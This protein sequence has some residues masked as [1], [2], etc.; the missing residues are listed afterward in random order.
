MLGHRRDELRVD[1]REAQWDLLLKDVTTQQGFAARAMYRTEGV[2]GVGIIRKSRGWMVL[3]G[4]AVGGLLCWWCWEIGGA[5]AAV[6]GTALF[7]FDPNF[8]GHSPLVKND[9]AMTLVMLGMMFALWR[10]GRR[11]TIW[12]LAAVCA[13]LA[14]GLG[15]KFSGVLLVPML[16]LILAIRVML[17]DEWRVLRWNVATRRGRLLVGASV[18]AAAMLLSWVLVWGIYSFR[19][20]PAARGGGQ[21][22]FAAMIQRIKRDSYILEHEANAPADVSALKAPVLA[23]VVVWAWE[24][25]VLPESW[26]FGLLFTY[27]TTLLR[28]GFLMGERSLT[29]WWY[30]FPVAMVWKTPVGTLAAVLGAAGV[31][32]VRVARGWFGWRS[33]G[34]LW[35]EKSP[36]P[37]LSRSTGRGEEGRSAAQGERLVGEGGAHP[38]RSRSTGRGEEGGFAVQGETLVG[39]GA[40][41]PVLS[42][43]T[44]RGE[45]GGSAGRG[46]RLVGEGGAHPVCS[47]STGRGEEGTQLDWWTVVCV[48]VPVGV[49]G[50]SAMRGHMNLG[51]RHMLAVVPFFYLIV[52]VMLAR[53]VLCWRWAGVGVAVLVLGVA[54]ETLARYPNYV[55]FFNV[56]AGGPRGGLALLSDSNLDWGQDLPALARWQREHP[57][58]TLCLAYFGMEDPRAHGIRYVN[59]PSGYF[60][61]APAKMPEIPP[62]PAVIAI[63]ATKLQGMYV[64]GDVARVYARL[65]GARP[66]EVLN[67]TI[68]IYS[69]R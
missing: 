21:F 48:V 56:A 42:R 68:Y 53:A 20:E 24:R 34:S 18:F 12:N 9:V 46:E 44:G 35:W 32:V 25:R 3:L 22:D 41:H 37:T 17:R 5:A 61:D 10:M 64:Y 11:L 27:Q 23:R 16:V 30:Y 40:S 69:L 60:L 57:R 1:E 67:G 59:L 26:L 62:G 29:G 65:R 36:H 8:L 50:L 47:R 39:E 52:A 13:A 55:A 7:A 33:E 43:S 6:I 38:V 51:V 45:E 54:A 31:G 63:S 2:D 28:P 4:M 15:T 19:F 49:Y 58:E 14:A 66:R